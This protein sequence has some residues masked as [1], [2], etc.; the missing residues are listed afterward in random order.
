MELIFLLDSNKLYI[1]DV[2]DDTTAYTIM[3]E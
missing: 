3:K 1:K 2:L